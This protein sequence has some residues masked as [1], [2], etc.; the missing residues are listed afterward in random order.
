MRFR[1]CVTIRR[2]KFVFFN[3]I[4]IGS[5]FS[6]FLKHSLSLAR[7][8][9]VIFIEHN[10]V[11]QVQCSAL[12]IFDEVLHGTELSSMDNLRLSSFDSRNQG[13]VTK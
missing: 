9:L 8:L 6:C 1:R 4:E 10:P 12:P 11:N 5:K 3:Y 7:L 13:G 2:K